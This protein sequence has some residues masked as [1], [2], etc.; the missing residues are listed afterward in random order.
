M[1]FASLHSNAALLLPSSGDSSLRGRWIKGL[2]VALCT[3]VI[4]SPRKGY[5]R[6][7]YFATVSR[8]AVSSNGLREV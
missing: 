2:P 7:L 8:R 5:H 1:S 6:L 3:L 4:C